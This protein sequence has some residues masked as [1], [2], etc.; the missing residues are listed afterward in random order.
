M[1]RK[2]KKNRFDRKSKGVGS[3]PFERKLIDP[4]TTSVR[5]EREERRIANRL[6][7]KLSDA[8]HLGLKILIDLEFENATNPGVTSDLLESW[9]RI[10]DKDSEDLRIYIKIEKER[11]TLIDKYLQQQEVLAQG[12]KLIRVWDH[13]EEKYRIIP[14]SQFEPEWMVKQ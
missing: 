12:E 7:I 1:D 2:S 6:H 11:Q 8:L 10:R 9:K 5:V 13:G 4:Y 14:E 3:M